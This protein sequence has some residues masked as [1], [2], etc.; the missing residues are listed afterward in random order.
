MLPKLEQLVKVFKEKHNESIVGITL[1]GST[2]RGEAGINSVFALFRPVVKTHEVS[3]LLLDLLAEEKFTG[4]EGQGIER[5]A[6]YAKILELKEHILTDYGDE[7]TYKVPW[8]IYK[9][10]H[11]KRAIEIASDAV[12][13][14]EEIVKAK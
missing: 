1:F 12:K 10:E 13:I 8:E 6:N 14:A 9:E 11:T 7:L 3:T 2:T 5:L 4:K